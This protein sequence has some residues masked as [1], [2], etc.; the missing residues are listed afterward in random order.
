ML[1]IFDWDG[2]LCNSLD[3]IVASAQR[4]AIDTGLSEP[5]TESVRSIVGLGLFEAI[6]QMF[7][8]LPAADREL[9][10][11]RYKY[12]FASLGQ[13]I[14]SPL[15]DDALHTLE[16]LR[17]GDH[18]I[19]VATGK[20]RMGLDLVLKEI[21]LVG[22]FDATRCADETRS[23]PHPLMLQEILTELD[24]SAADALMIGDTEFDLEMANA[25][26]MKSIGVTYG[27]H[28]VARLRKCN[29]EILVDDLRS[30]LE[31]GF[32]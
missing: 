26:G 3:R 11:S 24:Y 27:A 21:D 15:Y 5:S 4:S 12:H 28:G 10:V 30:I 14:P 31:F 8:N 7:P 13:E 29:P 17:A 9:M 22:Y 1:F 32:S 16:T 25:A 23:K 18:Q 2:T 6:D 19:A 20:S